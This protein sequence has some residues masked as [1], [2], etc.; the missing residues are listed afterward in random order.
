MEIELEDQTERPIWCIAASIVANHQADTSGRGARLFEPGT[1]VYCFPPVRGGAY[2]S[3]KVVGP[4]RRTG[5]LVSAVVPA[6]DLE[7]WRAEPVKD[8]E[9]L[10]QIAPPWDASSV[11]QGVAEGIAAWK[12]GGPWPVKELREWNRLHAEKVVGGGSL[13]TRLRNA[14]ARF[15]G[16]GED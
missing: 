3:V 16:R 2:E 8:A 11:S 6:T 14:L 15:F 1:K 4:N 13:L 9:V 7:K 10:Q 12:A 5:K